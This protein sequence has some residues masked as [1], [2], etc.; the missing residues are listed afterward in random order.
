ME[1]TLWERVVDFHGHECI[2]LASGYR[3]AE[4][5]MDALGDGRDIDEE[6]V[7]VVENDSCAVDAIQVV[8]GCT[9]GKGNLIFRD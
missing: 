3:V 2:G 6:M 1:K 7:A 8:T 4:A 5:A 9:L